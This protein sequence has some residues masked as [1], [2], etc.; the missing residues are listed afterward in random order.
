MADPNVASKIKELAGGVFQINVVSAALKDLSSETSIFA[1][2]ASKSAEA[3]NEAFSKNEA[4]NKSL[5]AQIN[6]LVVSATNLAEKLGQLTLGPV[7]TDLT[8]LATKFTDFLSN[9]LDEDSGNKF[10]QGFFKGIATFIQGPG[11]VLVTT[12]FL[13]IFKIV[14]KF[15]REGF[16]D[17]LRLSSGQEKIKSIEAGIVQLLAQDEGLRNQL[18]STTITQAQKEQL[19][20]QAIQRENALL[21][22]QQAIISSLAAASARAGVIGFGAGRGFSGKKGRGFASGF[23]PMEGAMEVAE[24]RSLGARGAVRPRLSQ[25]TIGGRKFVMNSQETEI[26][27]FGKNGDSA[28]I[29]NYA[30]GFVP[31]FNRRI[32]RGIPNK[33]TSVEDFSKLS[34][35]QLQSFAKSNTNAAIALKNRKE[36][37]PKIGSK[38]KRV[39][40]N[41]SPF[42]FLV[43]KIGFSQTLSQGGS[44]DTPKGKIFYNMSGVN[45]KGPRLP[46]NVTKVEDPE[47]ANLE[48]SVKKS[49][50]EQSTK[51]ARTL[52]DP[53]NSPSSLKVGRRLLG[54]KGGKGAVEAAVGAAFEAG[55][56]TA[57]GIDEVKINKTQGDFDLRATKGSGINPD[58]FKLFNSKRFTLG[59]FKA[60]ASRGNL[61]SF[62]K[63][64]L[65]NKTRGTFNLTKASYA[66][67]FIPNF[68]NPL[69]EAISRETS[70]TGIS[71]SQVRISNDERLVNKSNP[72]GLAVTNTRDEPNGLKDVFAK[73]FI[74]N[75]QD[76]P[77]GGNSPKGGGLGSGVGLGLSLGLSFLSQPL[78][79][80]I[81]SSSESAKESKKLNDQLS[82]LEK[83]LEKID[84]TVNPEE[85][86][87][88]S[89]E[90]EKV[91]EALKDVSDEA[92]EFEKK[93]QI[94]TSG[95]ASAVAIIGSLPPQL[96]I[97]AAAAAAGGAVGL[98]IGKF[99]ED[100]RSGLGDV[101]SSDQL[102]EENRRRF[103]IA[104]EGIGGA[105]ADGDIAKIAAFAFELAPLTQATKRVQEQF[106][107]FTVDPA[108]RE[109]EEFEK[110]LKELGGFGVAADLKTIN[111]QFAELG[112]STKELSATIQTSSRTFLNSF[113]GQDSARKDF[114]ENFVGGVDSRLSLAQRA[115]RI[116]FSLGDPLKQTAN[117]Q[118]KQLAKQTQADRNVVSNDFNKA[119]ADARAEIQSSLDQEAQAAGFSGL[120]GI[121]TSGG[122]QKDILAILDQ[123]LQSRSDDIEKSGFIFK[124]ATTEGG[125][126]QQAAIL[127]L[128]DKISKLDLDNLD[129][130]KAAEEIKKLA[131]SDEAK[132]L[133]VKGSE[134]SLEGQRFLT[135]ISEELAKVGKGEAI[136]EKAESTKRDLDDLITLSERG[137][138]GELS[139]TDAGRLDEISKRLEKA[140]VISKESNASLKTQAEDFLKKNRKISEDEIIAR[141][142]LNLKEIKDRRQVQQELLRGLQENF[143]ENL[144]G[145]QDMI[146]SGAGLG[147]FQGREIKAFDPDFFNT[148]IERGVT[149]EAARAAVG[150]GASDT[151]GLAGSLKGGTGTELAEQLRTISQA[152][153]VRG[154]NDVGL[155]QTQRDRFSVVG[156]NFSQDE[157]Q[158]LGGSSQAFAARSAIAEIDQDLDN[159]DSVADI[160]A[161]AT[162]IQGAFDLLGNIDTAGNAELQQKVAA[163]MLTLATKMGFLE[164][165]TSTALAPQSSKADEILKLDAEAE[166]EGIKTKFEQDAQEA[167]TESKEARGEKGLLGETTT[168]GGEATVGSVLGEATKGV[169]AFALALEST[170]KGLETNIIG[171]A[172]TSINV[173]LENLQTEAANAALALTTMSEGVSDL[174]VTEK[175][176]AVSEKV[177][178]AVS[179][180]ADNISLSAQQLSE[181]DRFSPKSP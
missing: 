21:R 164:K 15:A 121:D 17:L 98:G 76:S 38:E 167:L 93:V 120:S 23:T 6:T 57:L 33:P 49:V 52:I 140:G 82:N 24:A 19:V 99:N 79:D 144:R 65:K 171:D 127:N 55:V 168:E 163:A 110:R 25:G 166:A 132:L 74:P 137:E 154:L 101:V 41:A 152:A 56:A 135:S 149:E 112:R 87:E 142:K 161:V 160:S 16:Q 150:F 53:A 9:A 180:L 126:K 145:A 73:G 172:I 100:V 107:K 62:A 10:I 124:T 42:G 80:Y 50:L 67:G 130:T 181:I 75:F 109:A 89:A 46:E 47:A 96:A 54:Q 28:V 77:K 81:S 84:K 88:A 122:Q 111:K 170:A 91:K 58:L 143:G 125:R 12:A 104:R 141:T 136:V 158:G 117:E 133:G 5:A 116:D 105:I 94:T 44:F 64:I 18:V 35:T 31:N 90:I 70:G 4:L 66:K 139:E 71:K 3:S 83:E 30:Q 48:K 176:N 131:E 153:K 102:K 178:L 61:N 36:Q 27:N 32:G 43:P 86:A 26:P 20:I 1:D 72:L 169:A 114:N 147:D 34:T 156:Q 69:G 108:I 159:I 85:F 148:L 138:A 129:P 78:A 174:K 113:Q 8:N 95:I 151:K 59:E 40:I 37:A 106:V 51:F 115:S 146:N 2:A 173:D 119:I 11:I 97:P 157:F 45:V 13:N 165:I 22:E 60:S 39:N 177:A 7:L 134:E 128:Q 175:L 29:P 162:K 68:A 155:T 92:A 179:S 123:T 118:K 14:A 103:K 63:K